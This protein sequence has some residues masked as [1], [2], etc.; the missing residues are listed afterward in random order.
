[1]WED[2]EATVGDLQVP[3]VH[4]EIIGGDE[5][6]K[7][8]VDRD[9]VDVVGV[10]IAEHTFGCSLN[11]QVH[12]LQHWHLLEMGELERRKK[13]AERGFSLKALMNFATLFQY[14]LCAWML[15]PWGPLRYS[16]VRFHTT[17]GICVTFTSQIAKKQAVAAVLWGCFMSW[18]SQTENIYL[19]HGYFAAPSCRAAR[20]SWWKCWCQRWMWKDGQRAS[21]GS[22]EE[23]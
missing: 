6:L 19:P 22:A 15:L 11:H 2:T 23:W 20:K 9:G 8:R 7:V 3:Q 17:A 10:G 14:S 12:R 21:L 5:R 18:R 1:M 13:K 16:S 4:P